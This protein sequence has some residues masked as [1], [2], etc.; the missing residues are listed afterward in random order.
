[1]DDLEQTIAA[2]VARD[3]RQQG[4]EARARITGRDRARCRRSAN[5]RSHASSLI[6]MP[7]PSSML[8]A[9]SLV[10]ELCQAV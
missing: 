9:T 7:R 10:G 1:M 5:N 4:G 8:T 2:L 6:F 3:A